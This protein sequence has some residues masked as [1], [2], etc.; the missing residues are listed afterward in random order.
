MS[1][2]SQFGDVLGPGTGTESSLVWSPVIKS[3]RGT[4]LPFLFYILGLFISYI[5]FM[6]KPHFCLYLLL[7]FCTLF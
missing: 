7:S 2:N 3:R 6:I 5:L 1:Q 4:F